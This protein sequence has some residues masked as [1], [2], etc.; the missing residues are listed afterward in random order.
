MHDA[1]HRQ[2]DADQRG[3]RGARELAERRDDEHAEVSP[4]QRH[5]VHVHGMAVRIAAH[6]EQAAAE[7]V[8][9]LD[10]P[11]QADAHAHAHGR[12]EE[13]QRA[14]HKRRD[15]GRDLRHEQDDQHGHGGDVAVVVDVEEHEER[16]EHADRREHARHREGK[17]R[18]V[19]VGD[20]RPEEGA[21]YAH[22]A[23]A[24]RVLVDGV[25]EHHDHRGAGQHGAHPARGG[26]EP[27]GD[28]HAQQVGQQHADAHDEQHEG[29]DA[30]HGGREPRAEFA[31]EFFHRRTFAPGGTRNGPEGGEALRA[32]GRAG[33]RPLFRAVGAFVRGVGG[34]R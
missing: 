23:R 21:Q 34:C 12:L 22:A 17:H 32:P 15:V 18:E 20:Q 8:P 14:V 10:E 29:M 16:F 7:A 24:Q 26:V 27:A 30:G 4:A 19:E 28:V 9:H 2:D 33:L 1:D 13:A 25:L 11:Q 31:Q 6:A 3:E 5:G